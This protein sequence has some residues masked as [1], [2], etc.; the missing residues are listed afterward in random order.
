MAVAKGEVALVTN[1][2]TA[3][4]V[5]SLSLH[6]LLAGKEEPHL[7]LFRRQQRPIHQSVWPSRT[8]RERARVNEDPVDEKLHIT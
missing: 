3:R 4:R 8:E 6:S 7:I 5:N 2:T 1:T